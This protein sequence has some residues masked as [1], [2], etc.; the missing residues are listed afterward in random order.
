MLPFAYSIKM[1][2][3]VRMPNVRSVVCYLLL[4]LIAPKKE[5][6]SVLTKRN[7]V[8]KLVLYCAVLYKPRRH[9]RAIPFHFAHLVIKFGLNLKKRENLPYRRK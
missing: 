9:V 2:I 6:I 7:L 8:I 5:A 4:G 3:N 1:V